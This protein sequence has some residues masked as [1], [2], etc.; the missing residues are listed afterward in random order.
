MLFALPE[1]GCHFPETSNGARTESTQYRPQN[2][3]DG[4]LL[5]TEYKNAKR[6]AARA[7]AEIFCPG[8]NGLPFRGECGFW[9]KF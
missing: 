7:A 3:T 5:Q 9:P 8:L 4:I 6:C 1:N 2:I